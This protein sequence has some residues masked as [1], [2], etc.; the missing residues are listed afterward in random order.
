M[1]NYLNFNNKRK[2]VEYITLELLGVKQADN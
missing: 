1:H 2:Q